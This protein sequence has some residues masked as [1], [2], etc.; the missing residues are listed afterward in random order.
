MAGTSPRRW[1]LLPV[2][3]VALLASEFG[4]ELPITSY[5]S[6][7]DEADAG[8]LWR[9]PRCGRVERHELLAD[10]QCSGKPKYAHPFADA[11]AVSEDEGFT[12]RDDDHV[13]E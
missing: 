2:T 13:F 3:L 1:M 7:A 5:Q 4:D 12:P 9:C 6:G 10:P 8:Q 11:Q